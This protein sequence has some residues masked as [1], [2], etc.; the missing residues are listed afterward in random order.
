MLSDLGV[1]AD[2]YARGMLSRPMAAISRAVGHLPRRFLGRSVT[3]AG[4]AGSGLWFDAA[5][6][7]ALEDGIKQVAVIG[8][9]FDSRAWRL[10]REGVQFFEL[11]HGASQREKMRV[12]PGPGPIYVETELRTDATAGALLAHGLD[13]SQRAFFVVESVTM[14]LQE[15][16][17]R[18]L[19]GQLAQAAALGS[20]LAVNFLPSS[21]PETT[22]TQRQ[23]RLQRLAR[24]GS[25]ET[26]R[27]GTDPDEAVALVEAVGWTVRD[28]TSFRDAARA[29][30]PGDAGLP[31]EAI[32]ERKTLVLATRD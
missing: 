29:L 16:V 26:F 12:A 20:R 32:D 5:L 17:V 22:Q 28:R 13:S 7:T 30:V 1:L 15:E 24:I 18:R 27:F 8:A 2:P 23:L 11:D 3:L 6:T 19:L 14:Y 31:V 21:A 9:G 4:A 25:G 10:R